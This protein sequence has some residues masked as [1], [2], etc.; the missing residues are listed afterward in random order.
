MARETPLKVEYLIH[1]YFGSGLTPTN[2]QNKLK[3]DGFYRSRQTIYN[4]IKGQGKKREARLNG[5]KWKYQRENT[6]L[7]GEVL[8]VLK[9]R[10]KTEDPPTFRDLSNSINI[11]KSTIHHGVTKCLRMKS[12]QKTKVHV[13]KPED[14]KNRHT[15]SWKLYRNVLSGPKSRFVVT[16]DEAYI[17]VRQRGKK[18]NHFYVD[19]GEK[20][21]DNVPLPVNENFPEHFMIVGAMTEERTF[22][23]MKVPDKVKCNAQ[24]YVDYV[25]RPLIEDHLKP[26]FGDD[27]GKVTIHHDKAT[28]HTAKFTTSF[29]SEMKEKY[30]ISFIEKKDIPVKGC[31][32]SPMDFFGFGFLKQAVGRSKARTKQGVWK[33]CCDIWNNV[34]ASICKRTFDSWKKRCREV[35]KRK[36]DHIEHLKG[37]HSRKIKV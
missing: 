18:R 17:N 26:F 1:H 34:D 5:V 8:K 2:I 35:Q 19:V 6:V 13:L 32:I 23:L 31:D 27:L 30:G 9:K 15:N 4:V 37:I 21:M 28:A 25:L 20:L 11:P 36:G 7:T 10:F 12:K 22:P 24:F 3:E 14:K 29:L 16:L 33:K